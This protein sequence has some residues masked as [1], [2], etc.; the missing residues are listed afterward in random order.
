MQPI[1]NI[2]KAFQKARIFSRDYIFC[3]PLRNI[4]LS[5]LHLEVSSRWWPIWNAA[6]LRCIKR[7]FSRRAAAIKRR[8]R[9][10]RRN[11]SPRIARPQKRTT[12]LFA[13]PYRFGRPIIVPRRRQRYF[14]MLRSRCRYLL[15][16]CHPQTQAACC[17]AST[18]VI[19][20]RSGKV[21][22]A[23]PVDNK[24]TTRH[25]FSP[26]T[27]SGP[28]GKRTERRQTHRSRRR[29]GESRFPD[30]KLS[31]PCLYG[32]FSGKKEPGRKYIRPGLYISK[33]LPTFTSQ[34]APMRLGESHNRSTDRHR[35]SNRP[36]RRNNRHT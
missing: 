8:N 33:W 19:E 5:V 6:C 22:S 30:T 14:P 20:K 10:L 18:E 25:F 23:C 17:P 4:L 16:R 27:V 11:T 2:I 15:R 31:A 34:A 28:P 35:Q 13:P 7:R 12:F 1:A 32:F 21:H 3:G 36:Y 9:K 24:Q 29:I 26:H